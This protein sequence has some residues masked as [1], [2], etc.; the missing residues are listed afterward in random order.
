MITRG[1]RLLKNT[2]NYSYDKNE[3][4][5]DNADDKKNSV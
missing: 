3:G 1:L 4:T 5:N 2:T